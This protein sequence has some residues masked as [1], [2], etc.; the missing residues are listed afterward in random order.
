MAKETTLKY[1][2]WRETRMM[3]TEEWMREML[4]WDRIG[5]YAFQHKS[6]PEARERE[7]MGER[8]ELFGRG[9]GS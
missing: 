2:V 4:H 8:Y 1:H 7:P 9:S 3:P 6:C 5:W